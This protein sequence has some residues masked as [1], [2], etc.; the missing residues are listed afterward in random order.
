MSAQ[1]S[2]RIDP[3]VEKRGVYHICV[4]KKKQRTKASGLWP[5]IVPFE[6]LRE[7]PHRFMMTRIRVDS[8]GVGARACVFFFFDMRKCPV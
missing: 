4:R 5:E 3:K 8:K 6:Q 1:R 2:P 7:Y